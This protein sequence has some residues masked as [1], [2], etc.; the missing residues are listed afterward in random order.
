MIP[1]E[2]FWKLLM[3]LLNEELSA[4][5]LSNAEMAQVGWFEKDH[6]GKLRVEF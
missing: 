6:W 5:F 3:V 2:K 1:G 4:S